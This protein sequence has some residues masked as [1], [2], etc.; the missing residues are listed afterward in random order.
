M[1]FDTIICND[2]RSFAIEYSLG[3]L[4]GRKYLRTYC[5]LTHVIQI[6][7]YIGELR[8]IL[9]RLFFLLRADVKM[10]VVAVQQR[11]ANFAD[12]DN[13]KRVTNELF[14]GKDASS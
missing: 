13:L 12:L 4:E 7:Q 8:N 1:L 3:D 11:G 6:G 9:S 10:V 14:S 5:S 2:W